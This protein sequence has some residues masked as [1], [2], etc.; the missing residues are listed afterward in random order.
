[1]TIAQ[2]RY[3]SIV[4][5]PPGRM[6]TPLRLALAVGLLLLCAVGVAALHIVKEESKRMQADMKSRADVLIWAMEGAGRSLM[7]MGRQHSGQYRQSFVQ[8]LS[9][10]P[11]IAY[12]AVTDASGRVV[13]I[14]ISPPPT[15]GYLK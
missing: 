6:R 10:Q 3:S 4:L 2:S 7:Q 1:M 15:I 8:E 13:A 14:S 12:F 5:Q 9:R 11:N